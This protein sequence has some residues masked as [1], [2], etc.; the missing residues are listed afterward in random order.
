M[1][2]YNQKHT[3]ISLPNHSHGIY[4]NAGEIGSDTIESNASVDVAITS[5]DMRMEN[6]QELRMLL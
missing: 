6:L 5:G 1:E 3:E 2:A 4:K